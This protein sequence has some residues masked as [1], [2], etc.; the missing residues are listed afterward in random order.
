V[1]LRR[2]QHQSR[3]FLA[4]ARAPSLEAD[5]SVSACVLGFLQIFLAAATGAAVKETAS[6]CPAFWEMRVF[7]RNCFYFIFLTIKYSIHFIQGYFV[8]IALAIE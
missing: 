5:F 7:M 2:I 3:H 1:I 6:V 8:L 4:L